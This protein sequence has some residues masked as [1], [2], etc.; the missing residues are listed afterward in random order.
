[1]SQYMILIYGDESGWIDADEA[2]INQ[3]MQEHGAFSQA[4]GAALRGGE[5]LQLSAAAT[6]LRKDASG[7]FTVTDGPFLESKEVLGGYY[8]VEAADLDEAIGIAKQV[9]APNGGVEV[10]PIQVFS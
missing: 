9:P 2:T 7:A 8:I 3:S 1:M 5:A 6:S 10:R 4:A